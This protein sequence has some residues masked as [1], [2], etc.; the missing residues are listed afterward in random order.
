MLRGPFL[1]TQCIL[2]EKKGMATSLRFQHN[3]RR[4]QP[5]K[6]RTELPQHACDNW[7]VKRWVGIDRLLVNPAQINDQW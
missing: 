6:C 7:T 1:W 4:R 3:P 5:E 2:F